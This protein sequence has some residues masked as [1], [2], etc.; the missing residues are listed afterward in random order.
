V[1]VQQKVMRD[2][3]MGAFNQIV[4]YKPSGAEYQSTEV[5][6]KLQL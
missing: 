5:K 2:T 4:G 6:V 1:P 3:N